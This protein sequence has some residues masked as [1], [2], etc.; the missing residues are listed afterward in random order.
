MGVTDAGIQLHMDSSRSK[1]VSPAP[2]FAGFVFVTSLFPT[3][4]VLLPED[5][6][7][8]GFWILSKSE[9]TPAFNTVMYSAQALLK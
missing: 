3:T 6:A 7:Q 1:G 4:Q 9:A 2:L 5:R 8:Y